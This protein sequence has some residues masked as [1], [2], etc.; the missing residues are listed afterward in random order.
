MSS[1]SCE[2]G[3]FYIFVMSNEQ[4]YVFVYVD[5]LK[6]LDETSGILNIKGVG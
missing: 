4:F 6:F 3:M 1:V 5:L 2:G